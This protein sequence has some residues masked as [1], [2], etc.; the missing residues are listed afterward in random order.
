[1]AR[2]I[3]VTV[4]IIVAVLLGAF[5]GCSVLAASTPPAVLKVDRVVAVDLAVPSVTVSFWL[6]PTETTVLDKRYNYHVLVDGSPVTGSLY[7]VFH[8]QDGAVVPTGWWSTSL[9]VSGKFAK[10]ILRIDEY[11]DLRNDLEAAKEKD[12][13]VFN[14]W[15]W[16]R[17][18]APSYKD[19]QNMIVGKKDIQERIS[20]IDQYR[21]GLYQV[22]LTTEFAGRIKLVLEE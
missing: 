12:A 14:N 4:L 6:E 22:P 20:A 8:E 17:E 15:F 18:S 10:D 16:G 21:A 9:S 1:M 19:T 5:A 3:K 11:A 13:E 7:V 2:N